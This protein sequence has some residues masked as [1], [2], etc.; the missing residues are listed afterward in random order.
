[1]NKQYLSELNNFKNDLLKTIID[2]I[3]KKKLLDYIHQED[4]LPKAEISK[5]IEEIFKRSFLNFSKKLE[6]KEK[7]ID[8]MM[9]NEDL[10]NKIRLNLNNI[11]M[12]EIHI[13]ESQKKE[14]L[15][16]N[17]NLE[18][19]KV[20]L[21][22][23]TYM[24]NINCHINEFILNFLAPIMTGLYASDIKKIKNAKDQIESASFFKKLKKTQDLNV[25][26]LRNVY[27]LDTVEA[28]ND[29]TIWA[30]ETLKKNLEIYFKNLDESSFNGFD[31]NE[32]VRL[33]ANIDSNDTPENLALKSILFDVQ[34]FC[35]NAKEARDRKEL[36]KTQLIHTKTVEEKFKIFN[37]IKSQLLFYRN[38]LGKTISSSLEETFQSF[39]R[40][41][42]S[43]HDKFKKFT[44]GRTVIQDN[45]EK[46][47]KEAIN[48]KNLILEGARNACY[49]IYDILF[50][51]ELFG[52]FKAL[53]SR[54]NESIYTQE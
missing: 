26:N 25:R 7:L 19:E 23:D 9:H 45:Q 3:K 2:Q 37:E 13:L 27:L 34:T 51:E 42:E 41:K 39:R 17:M 15:N 1:M 43:F 35:E 8:F 6:L 24:K 5:D 33:N 53:I 18:I 11:F 31:Q 40:E 12:K 28:I 47:S 46:I 16:I 50:S 30:K 32:I 10:I 22:Q 4:D 54:Q 14:E 21:Q 36:R 48:Y 38:E 44:S 52:S 29:L 20:K 49:E